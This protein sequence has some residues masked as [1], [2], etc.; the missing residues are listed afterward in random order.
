M[1]R[2]KMQYR[3]RCILHHLA[4]S[5]TTHSLVPRHLETNSSDIMIL[6]LLTPDDRILYYITKKVVRTKNIKARHLL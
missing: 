2:I 6:S 5:F 3:I 4:G 1:V